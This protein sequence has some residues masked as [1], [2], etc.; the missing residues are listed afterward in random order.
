MERVMGI[1]AY[2]V[3]QLGDGWAVEHDGKIE[4]M[5]Y[6]TKEAAFEAIVGAASNSIKEGHEV[7][8]TVPGTAP[9]ESALV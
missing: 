1:A 6:L 4:G 3:R 2:T 9:G 8:I 7:R 5:N